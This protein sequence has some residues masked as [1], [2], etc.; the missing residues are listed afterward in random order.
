MMILFKMMQ[1]QP[2]QVSNKNK[3]IIIKIPYL[4]RMITRKMIKQIP[5]LFKK[6]RSK[7]K[8]I[9]IRIKNNQKKKKKIK[10]AKKVKTILTIILIIKLKKPKI[11]ISIVIPSK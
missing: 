1:I 4:R 11:L 9:L 10:S 8:K 2:L 3:M 7:N 6:L 5:I